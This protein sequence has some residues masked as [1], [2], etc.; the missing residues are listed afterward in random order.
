MNHFNNAYFIPNI[1]CIGYLCRT[2]LPSN[3][4]FRAFGAP[5]AMM[6]GEHIIRDLAR[7][8]N[9]PAIS[10]MELNLFKENDKT[11]WNQELTLCTLQRC[12]SECLTQSDLSRRAKEVD[13][14]NRQHRWR[15]RGIS[16]V[17]TTYSIGF[18]EHFFMQGG[19]LVL[20][21]TDGSVLLSHTGIEMGQGLHTKMIQ[22]AAR[23]LN[24]EEKL[25]FI[26]ET[27]TDKIPNTIATAAS[28]GSD[29]NGMAVMNAC[30][31]LAKRLKPYR[32]KYA[33]E[34]W[35]FCVNK[36]YM[37]RVSLSAA[38]FYPNRNFDF[39]RDL[40]DTDLH[41]FTYGAGV[42]EVEIDCL[43]GDHQVLR[44]DIV[45]DVGTS[46]NPA[47]DIGQI[48]GAYMQGYGL[49]TM[50]EMIYSPE[51]AVYS[52]GPG[53][54]KL[55]GFGDIPAVFNVSLL[56]G[57]SN[58]RAVYSSK[59]IGEPPLFLSAAVFFAIKEAIGAAR[60]DE[61]MDRNVQLFSPAT[62]AKIRM[63]CQD[64]FTKPVSC[65]SI[66]IQMFL[67]TYTFPSVDSINNVGVIYFVL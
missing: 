22:I 33:N 49:Y 26:S 62:A 34:T 64:K 46:L 63:A 3:T 56:K 65:Y 59:A 54:Y 9:K 39:Q 60:A 15:K 20:V 57:S 32:E 27:A 16:I 67:V 4:A 5:Q 25:I 11:I 12:W 14:F 19:A 24:I 44:T 13:E 38:G 36:A 29:L 61:N 10:I 45:M 55:P 18:S 28:I 52:R 41:Y 31:I 1:R 2:N 51:G 42:S 58:P 48:E 21:Y 17:P 43:T 37:D 7:A 40:S 66:W 35:T 53:M 47:I 23:V 50:E 6:V 8:M 30:Q